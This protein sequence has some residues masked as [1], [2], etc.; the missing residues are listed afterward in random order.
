VVLKASSPRKDPR[1]KNSRDRAKTKRYQEPAEFLEAIRRELTRQGIGAQADLPL[2]QFGD[3]AGLPRRRVVRIHGKAIVGFSVIV[4]GL[5]G[6]E[7]LKLQEQGLGGRGKMGCG[8]FVPVKERT[9][10]NG[11]KPSL[12]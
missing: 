9:N 2:Q 5:T 10:D 6:E 12:G 1:D 11:F 4:Q 8:F 3:R 7:S